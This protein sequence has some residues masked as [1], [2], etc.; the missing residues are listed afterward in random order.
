[1]FR[2][3]KLASIKSVD[4]SL[5]DSTQEEFHELNITSTLHQIEI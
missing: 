1:M 2:E 4:V 5:V 3:S